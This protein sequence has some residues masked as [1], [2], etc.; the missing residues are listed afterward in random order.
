MITLS[1]QPFDAGDELKAFEARA[2]GAGAIVSFTGLVRD[3]ASDENVRILHLQAYSPMTERGIEQ[4]AAR[5]EAR[6]PLTAIRIL[7]R[8]GDMGP[9]EPIVFVATASAHRRDAFEAADFLMDYLKT[10]AVFWKKEV[11][12]TGERWIEPR[13]EDYQDSARWALTGED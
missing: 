9:G 11:T 7:H 1:A 5:A 13:A 10:E 4:A 3:R 12:D 8:I 6:W 2:S